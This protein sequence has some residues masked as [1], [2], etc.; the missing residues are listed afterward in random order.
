MKSHKKTP[1]QTVSMKRRLVRALVTL[2]PDFTFQK[3]AAVSR[4]LGGK[5][6]SKTTYA[7]IRRTLP[8][9]TKAYARTY[10][11][12]E[13]FKLLQGR[14][15]DLIAYGQGV[16]EALAL[17]NPRREVTTRDVVLEMERRGVLGQE[18]RRH[19]TGLIFARNPQF[20]RTRR[21]L[22]YTSTK[23][24]IHEREVT[25]WQLVFVG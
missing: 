23:R 4:A 2:D 14:H 13:A 16:A 11:T 20:K 3:A 9:M 12:A 25:V 10:S 19:W 5:G 6:I 21:R 18:G 22:S 17:A 15:K 7:G 8:P 24:N 1:F